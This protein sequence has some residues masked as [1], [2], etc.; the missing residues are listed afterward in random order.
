MR[1]GVST[2]CLYP[3]E[4]EKSLETLLGLG[5]QTYECFF[6]TFSELKKEYL[7]QFRKRLEETGSNVCSVH[8][9]FSG[10]EHYLLFSSY[11]RRFWD[12]LEFY[13]SYLEAAQF[14]GA[15]YCVIHGDNRSV[16]PEEEYFSRFYTIV[17]C[18]KTFGI[19]VVQENVNLFRSANPDFILRMRKALGKDAK[20]VFDIKQAVRAG[21]E[22]MEV[23]DAM[24]ENVVHIHVSDNL[25][26]ED[27]LLPGTGRMDFAKLRAR[28]DALNYQGEFMIE[29]YRHN[30]GEPSDLWN[31]A[32]YLEPILFPKGE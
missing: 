8:P 32:Q 14:L 13:K 27:C 26:G 28:L 12:S 22:P 24:G 17:E 9:F 11:K 3:M 15:K 25:P 23:L 6:N 29:L 20:F 16:I 2:A 21:W 1:V 4:L 5:F 31:A 7:L 18:G 30:F 10:F 19:T